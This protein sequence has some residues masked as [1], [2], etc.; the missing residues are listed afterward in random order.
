M[1]DFNRRQFLSYAI[2]LPLSLYVPINSH[3]NSAGRKRLNGVIHQ[4]EGD[5]YIN[6]HHA[7]QS[8]QITAGNRVT[9]AHG[10]K[11]V[12]SMGEDTYLLQEGSSLE[13]KSEDNVIVSSLTLLTGG[14]L[15]VFGA[16]KRPTKIHTRTATIGIR[17]TGVY[18]NSQPESLYFCTC[19]GNTD[20]N[21]GHNHIE[22]IQATHHSAFEI[23]GNT[24]KTTSMK[25]TQVL[26]HTDDELRML[27]QYSGRKPLFDL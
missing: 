21:L 26:N 14:L 6:K 18:L 20:L 4:L 13:V 2:T 9:V 22:Q 5:V 11:L 7:N 15:A 16:R 23:N 12:F 3:A 19:Y 17:G 1:S 25:A 27:E 8:S 24:E 10:G